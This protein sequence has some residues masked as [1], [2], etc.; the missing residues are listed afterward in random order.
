MRIGAAVL[1]ILASSGSSLC[2]ESVKLSG[3]YGPP[4]AEYRELATAG[5]TILARDGGAVGVGRG[6]GSS[7]LSI[8]A[9]GEALTLSAAGAGA[10][11]QLLL[12][13]ARGSFVSPI[14]PADWDALGAIRA[15]G[16]DGSFSGAGSEAA[17]LAFEIDGDGPGAYP[18]R[19]SL[20]TNPGPG[21][22]RE[23]IAIRHD[24]RVGFGTADPRGTLDLGPQGR[25]YLQEVLKL[26]EPASAC[27]RLEF[28]AEGGA[29]IELFGTLGTDCLGNPVSEVIRFDAARHLFR[30]S[31]LPGPFASD[32]AKVKVFGRLGAGLTGSGAAAPYPAAVTVQGAVC[33]DNPATPAD[34]CAGI[35]PGQIVSEGPISPPGSDLAERFQA[36]EA[37]DVGDVVILENER[38]RRP[39]RPHEAGVI[40]VVSGAAGVTLGLKGAGVPVAL[41]GRVPVKAT[42][43]NGAIGIGDFLVAA[44]VPGFAM[45]ADEPQD[46]AVVGKALE[47]LVS[48][49]GVIG[50]WV[51][52]R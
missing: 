11:G 40:G 7:K 39:R 26:A 43:A 20:A 3:Y 18:G 1:S 32:D 37:L 47:A 33:V 50:V 16:F 17:R 8:F 52:P 28:L 10:P 30:G 45:R 22:P 51:E 4:S 2:A 44:P 9:E 31:L 12:G 14:V 46:G 5:R 23:R 21:G 19:V 42:A 15:I 34:P 35:L 41:T 6:T 48:G 24:G 49:E 13:R 27:N 25:V 29:N 38:L 36:S